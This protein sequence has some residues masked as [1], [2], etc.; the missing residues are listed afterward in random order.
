MVPDSDHMIPFERPDAVVIAIRDVYA[1]SINAGSGAS[2]GKS[3][4]TGGGG[5]R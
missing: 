5:S 2:D 3:T 4:A 1:A